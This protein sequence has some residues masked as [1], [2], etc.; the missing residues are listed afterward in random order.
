MPAIEHDV[1]ARPGDGP[2]ELVGLASIQA[3]GAEAVVTTRRGGVSGGPYASLNLGDHV[4]D[5]PTAVAENRRRLAGFFGVATDALVVVRQVHGATAAI[6]D[7]ATRPNE[8]DA[9]VTADPRVVVCVLVADCVP[10]VVL[11]PTA[12]VLAVVH[13]GWRGTVAGVVGA[14][15]ERMVQLGAEP[16]RCVAAMGPCISGQGYQVGDEVAAA[17]D[18]VGCAAAVRPD[19]AGRH[20]ADLSVACRLQLAAA[21]VPPASVVLP[22]A[23]T[24]KG[25]RFFSDRAARPCGRFALAARLGEAPS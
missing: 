17:L 24:D 1:E 18:Q 12:R 25:Q 14:T 6:V 3:L 22:T 13:A 7:A 9:L 2:L 11:D 21:G 23:Y 19:G 15:V 16:R 5:D 10:V 4:G 8:A 20:L